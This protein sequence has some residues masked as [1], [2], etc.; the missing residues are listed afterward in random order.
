MEVIGMV[1]NICMWVMTGSEGICP[2]EHC[3]HGCLFHALHYPSK[4]CIPVCSWLILLEWL[5][6]TSLM[7]GISHDTGIW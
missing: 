1:I 2:A 6:I 4:W 7:L 5:N 3:W